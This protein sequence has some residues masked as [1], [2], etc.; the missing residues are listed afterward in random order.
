MRPI[1]R[2]PDGNGSV[3]EQPA[4]QWRLRRKLP[5]VPILVGLWPTEDEVLKEARVRAIIGADYCSTSLREAV[6]YCI[7]AAHK[8]GDARGSVNSVVEFPV[9]FD[10]PQHPESVHEEAGSGAGRPDHIR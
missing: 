4:R 5:H 3:G 1:E 8:A 6:S 10:Q 9:A 2:S 7:E